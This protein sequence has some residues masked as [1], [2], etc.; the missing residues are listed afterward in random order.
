M[1]MARWTGNKFIYDHH[2]TNDYSDFQFI[3]SWEK[4]Y[5]SWINQNTLPVKIIK[6]E[7]LYDKTFEVLKNIIEFINKLTNSKINFDS[8]KAKNSIQSSSFD[9]LKKIEETDGFLELFLNF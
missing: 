6:Y 5:K 9:K 8:K 3:S 4:N 7:D 2:S 1:C